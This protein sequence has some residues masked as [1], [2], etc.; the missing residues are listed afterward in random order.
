MTIPSVLHAPRRAAR[1]IAGI[2]TLV[3]QICELLVD[4]TQGFPWYESATT[5]APAVRAAERM[6]SLHT[7][8]FLEPAATMGTHTSSVN[9]P[10]CNAE[11]AA[12]IC[13]YTP[14]ST[15]TPA[16]RKVPP[17]KYA[18]A[19]CHGSH[20]GTSAA[21]SLTYVKWA[22]PKGIMASP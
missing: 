20:P 1:E 12:A 17:K 13:A 5:H 19:V 9:M 6:V 11:S 18:Q 7:N 22:T 2:K 4:P 16:A 15:A 10:I 21:V 14:K 8:G 3:F